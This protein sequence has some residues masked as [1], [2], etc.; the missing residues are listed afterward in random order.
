MNSDKPGV[1]GP[2]CPVCGSDE[3]YVRDGVREC[4]ICPHWE[5][6]R[7]GADE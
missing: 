4:L 1:V 5:I 6:E 2:K 3:F 7:P